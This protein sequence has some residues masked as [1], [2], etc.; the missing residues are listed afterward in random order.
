MA[1]IV[2][3]DFNAT[4]LLVGKVLRF[5]DVEKG[6]MGPPRL[7]N[8]AFVLALYSAPEARKLWVGRFDETQVLLIDDPIR[9][10]A[11]P[12]RGSRRMSALE[13][14]G[15]GAETAIEAMTR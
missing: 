5:R 2:A 10:R 8:V 12:G 11:Y 3:Q 7:A 1:E 14:A 9:A 4:G 6:G 13:L 15:F